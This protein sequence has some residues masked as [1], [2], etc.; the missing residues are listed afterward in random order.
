MVNLEVHAGEKSTYIV[1]ATFKDEDGTLV[2]PSLIAWTLTDEAG[3]VINSR[4][5][6]SVLAPASVIS[7]LLSG[8]DLALQVGE[9]AGTVGRVVTVNAEY[10]ST[11]GS[12]LP[13]KGEVRFYIDNLLKVS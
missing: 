11:L 13:L 3:T 7:I 5:D 6:V 1:T 8:L 10:N 12:G 4:S 9:T 2:V